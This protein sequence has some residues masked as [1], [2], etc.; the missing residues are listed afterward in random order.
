[1]TIL[2]TKAGSPFYAQATGNAK[3]EQGE[4]EGLIRHLVDAGHDVVY[5]GQGY[6]VPCR[7]VRPNI[8]GFNVDT[9]AREQEAGW[10]QDRRDILQAC[11][12]R[13]DGILVVCGYSPTMVSI[14]NPKYATPQSVSIRLYGPQVHLIHTLDLPAC[15][16]NCDPRTTPK[17]Q[18]MSLMWP[19]TQP[20][21]YLCQTLGR[22]TRQRVIGGKKYKVVSQYGASESWG[23]LPDHSNCFGNGRPVIMGHSHIGQGIKTGDQ[24]VWREVLSGVHCPV[25]GLGWEWAVEA[26]LIAPE[27]YGGMLQGDALTAALTEYSYC[28]VVAHTPGFRTGKPYVLH[29]HGVVPVLHKTYRD[30]CGW[31]EYPTEWLWPNLPPYAEAMAWW[32]ERLR[33]NFEVVDSVV[34]HMRCRTLAR[35]M[36]GGFFPL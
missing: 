20:I 31:D 7:H 36:Y 16:I 4:T 1:M 34:E 27:M 15:W 21:A 30:T 17:F 19:N 10:D 18:E 14:T 25:Y 28:P 29:A 26:G 33:P 12:G 35:G 11:G 6:G 32:A 9:L 8:E 23:W 13:P 2:V 22:K 24:E 3:G 5:F